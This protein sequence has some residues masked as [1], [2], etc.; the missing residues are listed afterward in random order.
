M[1]EVVEKKKVLLGD[2]EYEYT[3]TNTGEES[4]TRVTTVDKKNINVVL[5]N[6]GQSNSKDI[7]KYIID[8]LS[9]LYIQRNVKR[10]I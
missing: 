7:E 2:E 6:I 8:V 10:L 1:K 9:D 5:K 4:L 3:K